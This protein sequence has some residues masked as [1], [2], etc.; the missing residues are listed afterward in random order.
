MAFKKIPD[1]ISSI[2][3]LLEE[4][5]EGLTII[6]ISELLGMNRNSAANS[7]KLLQM[8]GRVTLKK[9]GPAK[10]YCL[11]NKL[12]VNAVLR[13]TNN[14][15]IVF[16]KM[17]VTVDSN[18]PIL[19][20]LQV[21]KR[22]L[23]GKN[24]E[25]IPFF[26]ESLPE[27][28]RL[29]REGLKGNENRISTEL[30][31]PDRS[32]PCMLS[33]CPIFF[34]SGEPGAALIAD[35]PA[36]AQYPHLTNDRTDDTI[37]ELDMTEY[38]CR[39]LPDGT[40]T[41]V[42]LAYCNL[43]NKAKGELIGHKCRPIVPESEYK[44][45]KTCL[46][47][48]DPTHPVSSLEFKT[49]T[50]RGESRWQRW[51]FRVLS[52]RYGQIEGYQGTGMDITGIKKSEEKARKS[53]EETE[54]LK[55]EREA[56][57]QELNKQIYDEIASHEKTNFQLQFTQFAMEKASYMITWINY[58]GRFIYMNKEAQQVL[59]YQ[60]RDVNKKKIQ[61]TIAGFFPFPWDEIWKTIKRDRIYTFET[62]LLTS[63]GREIP[64]EMV[65]NYLEFKDKQ[66]C[67]CFAKD[68]TV[69]KKADEALRETNEY[70][71]N[72]FDYANAPIIVWDPAFVITRFN[73]AFEDLTKRSELEV[74]GQQLHILFPEESREISLLQIEKT[75]DGERWEAV[76]IPILVKDGSIRTVLWNS[77]NI[78]DTDG[79]ITFTIAQG[80]D[81]TERKIAEAELTRKNEE[82]NTSYEQIAAVERE[83]RSNLEDMTSAEQAI[84]EREE[85]YRL[86]ADNGSDTIW[87]MRLDGVFTYHSP[88]VMNLRGLSPDEA[89][90]VSLE[91]TLCPDSLLFVRKMFREEAE[92]PMCER[93]S[94]R[95]LELEMY[96]KDGTTIWTD[97]SVRAIRDKDD[98]IIGLQGSTRDITGRRQMEEALRVTLVKYKTLFDAFPLGI[99]VSDPDGRIIEYN[100]RAEG[101][102]GLPQVEHSLRDIDGEEWRI[103]HPDGTPMHAEEYASVRALR[104]NRLVENQE[105]GIVKPTGETT[106]VS[107]T[108]APLPV[109]GHGVVITYGDITRRKQAEESLRKH[110]YQITNLFENIPI[111][112][113]QSTPAGKVIFVN[114]AMATLLGYDSPEDLVETVNKATVAEVLYKDPRKHPEFLHEVQQGRGSWKTY[115]NQYRKKGGEII[116][117]LLSISEHPDPET[118][119]MNLY[120]FMQDLTGHKLVKEALHKKETNFHALFDGHDSIMLLVEPD[121][122]EIIDANRAA[123]RF[124]GRSREDLCT[125]SIEKINT[126]P[127][128]E[129]ALL[130]AKV[131]QG[132]VTSFIAQ[133]RLFNGEVRAVEVYSSPVTMGGKTVLFSIIQDSNGRELQDNARKRGMV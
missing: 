66:Y 43:L 53:A 88:A 130:R 104:E 13:L 94:D 37:T 49:I 75:L 45:I 77:A 38:V 56:E 2:R 76:E 44:K 21:T 117:V 79:R 70:L 116:D 98:S 60:Y 128:E 4:N 51:K 123:E 125:L 115:E 54:T 120:G 118:G 64:V 119:I 96:R 86:L 71:N 10:I 74:I 80:V 97:V 19:E 30:V 132:Q 87:L 35:I 22:D 63:R 59:G 36:G 121:T 106:W 131:A 81:I 41:Y 110:D 46:H 89:N 20:L 107:V 82:L 91:Q 3:T 6:R 102:P 112:M 33:I 34:E 78:R 55:R 90:M 58:E 72:L 17:G 61:D 12:P 23:I 129:I 84:R 73:H 47:T 28:P 14:G 93:W 16:N 52:D 25:K 113:F 126:M 18:E 99:T 27:L 109:K 95:V 101:F 15:V 114:P 124:Y 9:I 133:H 105:M 103:V 85:Q 32:L 127:H 7:L 5:P 62:R 69:E 67:C 122:G 40:L 65:L 42:N 1:E 83:L 100:P 31:L 92:K 8:Q 57:F 108:A 39:F 48:L 26:T 68:I 24:I 111:G 50:P 11:A 29:I